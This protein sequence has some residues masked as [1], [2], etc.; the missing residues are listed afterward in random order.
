MAE[1]PKALHATY[2]PFL[3]IF[4]NF[5]FLRFKTKMKLAVTLGEIIRP[6][7]K[8]FVEFEARYDEAM[9]GMAKPLMGMLDGQRHGKKLRPLL[10]LLSSIVC[11]DVVDDTYR[12]AIAVELLHTATLFHDDVVDEASTRRDTL[13][14]NARWG[15]KAAVLIGDYVLAQAVTL[16]AE[17]KNQEIVLDVLD[18][19]RDMGNGELVQMRNTAMMESS[20]A[21]YIEVIK[22]KTA[23]L[24]SACCMTGAK[25]ANAAPWQVDALA[26]YGLYFGIAFQMRDDLLDYGTAEI[27]KP[28]GSDLNEGKFTLPLIA[29]LAT[30]GEPERKTIVEDIKNRRNLEEIANAVRNGEGMSYTENAI[31]HYTEL[32]IA[33]LEDFSPDEK[34]MAMEQLARYCGLREK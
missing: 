22:H 18:A 19:T 13:S 24:L 5:L 33:Q 11:G 14:L 4:K 23:S 28:L 25:A 30:L 7:E 34:R 8:E 31:K 15:N 27:G 6:I 32:A 16:L 9:R 1:S 20:E 21:S 3:F 12:T 17:N 2:M 10:V 26:R 29:H